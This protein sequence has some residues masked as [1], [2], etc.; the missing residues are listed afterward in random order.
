MFSSDSSEIDAKAERLEMDFE[1]RKRGPTSPGS[2]DDVP[3]RRSEDSDHR[4]RRPLRHLLPR[5]P[6]SSLA[7]LHHGRTFN[8]ARQF[9]P[10]SA[11]MRR[12][13]YPRDF[14]YSRGYG[15]RI[16]WVIWFE[17]F[18]ICFGF[19]CKMLSHD[20]NVSSFASDHFQA[21]VSSRSVGRTKFS[22]F[23]SSVFV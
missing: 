21:F 12:T 15:G 1:R 22:S 4:P 17:F 7:P 23:V 14:S 13:P 8:A 19:L 20:V 5:P 10:S 6:S 11:N 16:R 2:A 9:P 3:A 18:I